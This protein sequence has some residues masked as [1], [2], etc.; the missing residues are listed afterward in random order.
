MAEQAAAAP[1]TSP[2][3]SI[4]AAVTPAVTPAV[5]G[6][7]RVAPIMGT[8]ISIDVRDPGIPESVVDAMLARLEEIEARFS[9]YRSGSEISR[10]ARGELAEA[11][12]SAEVRFV[13]GMCDD[14]HRTTDGWFDARGHRADGRLDPSGL[15]KGWAVEE[16]ALLLDEAGARNY[17]C[18]CGGDVIARGE[19]E[20]GRPWRVGIRHPDRADAVARVLAVRDLAVATSGAYERG[21]HIRDPRTGKAPTGLLSVT[22]VGPSLTWA[23]VYATTAFA[24][25]EAGPAWVATHSGYGALA[26]TTDQRLVWT[27]LVEPLLA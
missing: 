19:P 3:A 11:D 5:R 7:H 23:D 26:I 21:D 9:T 13:L 16:A 4:A 18:N 24:M 14:L 8:V 20:P 1:R 2:T 17:S 12:A 15:V 10:I 22:V 27:P 25:G 6:P